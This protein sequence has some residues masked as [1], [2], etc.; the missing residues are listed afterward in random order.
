VVADERLDVIKADF[1]IDFPG[2]AHI[3]NYIYGD[4]VTFTIPCPFPYLCTLHAKHPSTVSGEWQIH[5]EPG[6]SDLQIRPLL[7]LSSSSSSS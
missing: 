6:H 1:P 4:V 2:I 5:T 7:L 3:R